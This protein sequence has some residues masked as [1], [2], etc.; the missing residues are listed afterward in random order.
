MPIPDPEEA[1]LYA[2]IGPRV[3]E[4]R[5]RAKLTQQSLADRIR[6]SRVDQQHRGRA[7]RP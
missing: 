4:A 2:V 7:A 5:E 1:A 3:R 6:L